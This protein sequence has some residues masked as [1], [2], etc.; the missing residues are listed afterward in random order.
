MRR[1]MASRRVWGEGVEL[2]AELEAEEG[3]G[4]WKP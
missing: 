3:E 1:E 2:E 4:E